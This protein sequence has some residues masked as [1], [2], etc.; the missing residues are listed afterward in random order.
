MTDFHR[1]NLDKASSPYLQQHKNNP[2]WWQGWGKETLEY[3]RQ[4]AKPLFASVGYATCHWCHAMA[5][6]AFS[7]KGVAQ[8]LNENFVSM[9]VDREQRPD[10]DHFLMAFI[11]QTQGQG[12]WPL[13]VFLTPDLKPFL[14]LTYAPLQPRYGMPAFIQVLQMAKEA[15]EKRKGKIPAFAPQKPMQGNFEEPEVIGGILNSFDAEH[16]GFGSAPKFPAHNTMLFLISY[17]EHTQDIGVKAAIEKTLDTTALRGLH[18]HLQG[19]FYRYCVDTAWTIPHFEKMLYDQ[20]MLLWVYSAAYKV[21]GKDE[22]RTIAGKTVKCLEE[23]FENEAGLFYSGHDADTDHEEGKTYLWS[24]QEIEAL[25][26]K[27]EAEEFFS[28]YEVTKEGNFEGKN[29]LVKKELVFLQTVEEKLLRARKKREQPFTDRKIL[30]S[31]NCLA[32]IALLHAYRYCGIGKA[33]EKAEKTFQALANCHYKNDWLSHSSL[34]G[35]LQNEEFLEDYAA[36]LLFAT[37]LYEEGKA[38]ESIVRE[39]SEKVLWFKKKGIWI[40]NRAVDFGEM[41]APE[42]DHPTPSASSLAGLALFRTG[43]ITGARPEALEYSQP[44]NQD[45]HNLAGFIARGNLHEVHSPEKIG[46]E[47]MPLNAMQLRGK[48]FEDC[49]AMQCRQFKTEEELAGYLQGGNQRPL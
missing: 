32:G 16:G 25:L 23:T 38:T 11:V 46:W 8:Y 30:T 48:K 45:F 6:E 17:F 1:N 27:K 4:T 2:V 28:A 31:W 7:D 40:E 12:G 41:P 33:L 26:G 18:D 29:H 39:L 49:Y 5:N 3:A 14:A 24:K 37:Y 42:F 35:T 21:L 44:L 13:N 43:I 47:K 34:E 36:L 20:A 9:K 22:Y 10:I 15:Y 19:G